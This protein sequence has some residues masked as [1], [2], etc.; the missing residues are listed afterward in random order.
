[1]QSPE[2]TQATNQLLEA[3]RGTDDF[4]RYSA[5]KASVMGDDVNRR[6]LERFT[7]V[8]TAL[9]M[10]ALAGSE[11]RPEDASDYERLSALLYESEELTEYLLSQ[12][13]VQ[14][15]VASTMERL[16]HEVGLDIELPEM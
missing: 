15:L 8:Q 3:L 4:I 13:R 5:L 10:A 11:P 6:L 1:M 16:T 14:Q 9:Q 12:M 7:R 2:V